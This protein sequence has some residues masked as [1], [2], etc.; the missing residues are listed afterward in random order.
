MPPP[1]P[2]FPKPTNTQPS[3][4]IKPKLPHTQH[5]ERE[6]L[7]GS[8][9]PRA[10]KGNKERSGD[11]REQELKKDREL[12][13]RL[14]ELEREEEEYLAKE[15][16]RELAAAEKAIAAVEDEQTSRTRFSDDSGKGKHVTANTRS[17]ESK[18]LAAASAGPLRITIK[19]T[20]L[21]D[22]AAPKTVCMIQ[23]YM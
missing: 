19:H 7:S 5:T 12:W 8:G 18:E 20:P 22:A 4:H 16:E 3:S 9:G 2:A 6:C 1:R 21:Q 10:K 15:K 17:H 23:S 11:G 14:D 13:A